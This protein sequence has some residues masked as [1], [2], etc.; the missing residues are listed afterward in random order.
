MTDDKQTQSEGKIR[1][2]NDGLWT[3]EI[4]GEVLGEVLGE[5][6]WQVLGAR[7][8]GLRTAEMQRRGLWARLSKL[9]DHGQILIQSAE[10]QLL[11]LGT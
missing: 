3:T 10:M 7:H 5:D 11:G 6:H 2:Q 8:D 4:L 9:L 1:D